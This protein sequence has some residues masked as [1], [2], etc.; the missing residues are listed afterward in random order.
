MSII[1]YHEQRRQSERS[2][3]HLGD[4][5]KIKKGGR[6][7]HTGGADVII[8]RVTNLTRLKIVG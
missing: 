4:V 8:T 3:F 1:T 7:F 6:E 5:V 2:E